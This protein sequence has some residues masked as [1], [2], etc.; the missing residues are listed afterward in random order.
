MGDEKLRI[1]ETLV[2]VLQ[3][4]VANQRIARDYGAGNTLFPA[5]VH[6]VM[7]IN[8]RPGEGVTRLATA[9]GVTKGAVSQ[10]VGRLEEKGL[11]TRELVPG[12][13]LRV[14]FVLTENGRAAVRAHERMHARE[15]REL[16]TFLDTCSKRE[17]STIVTFLELLETG[18]DRRRSLK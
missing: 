9:S 2:R 5:E 1:A 11:I 10:M 12:N 6:M 3:K 13:D 17:R 14:N 7:L 16:L 15:D 8:T 18:M 4:Y